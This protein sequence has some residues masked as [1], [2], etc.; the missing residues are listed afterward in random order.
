[1]LNK[2]ST[3]P[4]FAQLSQHFRDY[5]CHLFTLKRVKSR[6]MGKKSFVILLGENLSQGTH[7]TQTSS[8]LHLPCRSI[9]T[10]DTHRRDATSKPQNGTAPALTLKQCNAACK[11]LSPMKHCTSDNLKV[12]NDFWRDHPPEAGEKPDLGFVCGCQKGYIIASW[13]VTDAMINGTE[14]VGGVPC[15]KAGTY[16]WHRLRTTHSNSIQIVINF[17]TYSSSKPSGCYLATFLLFSIQTS[18]RFSYI[19]PPPSLLF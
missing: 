17:L 1:M 3:S 10:Q 13:M 14:S 19:A 4:S 5:T 15:V 9:V 2:A 16:P 8:Y 6:R 7:A 11:K 12:A 18:N